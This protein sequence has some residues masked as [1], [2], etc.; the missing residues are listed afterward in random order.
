LTVVYGLIVVIARSV[1]TRQSNAGLLVP[2]TEIRGR[3][4]GKKVEADDP[5][6]NR[7]GCF[8]PDLTRL[9][10]APSADFRA[11]IWWHFPSPASRR[12]GK[13]EAVEGEAFYPDRKKTLTPTLSRVREREYA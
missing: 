8:L 9:A 1:A 13:R 2:R 12:G 10:T 5:A 7:C 6:P 3:N 4:D 11:G